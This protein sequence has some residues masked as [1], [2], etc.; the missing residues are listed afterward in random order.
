MAPGLV[1]MDISTM[2]LGSVLEEAN[3]AIR[4]AIGHCERHPGIKK[5][6]S[7]KIEIHFEPDIH[8]D[9]GEFAL[10]ITHCSVPVCPKTWGKGDRAA[11]RDGQYQVIGNPQFAP[12][13]ANQISLAEH[14][15]KI[16]AAQ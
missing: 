14:M 16:E 12:L 15:A 5:P 1:E 2:C 8:E 13:E 11:K 7:V 6:R 3:K 4:E 9:T 10:N